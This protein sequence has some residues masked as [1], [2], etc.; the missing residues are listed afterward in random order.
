MNGIIHQCKQ[1]KTNE[2]EM[3]IAVFQYI[4][5]LVDI[6]RPKKY[7]FMG[8]DGNLPLMIVDPNKILLG[9]APRA[10][11]NE[12]RQR[13]WRSYAKNAKKNMKKD[14]NENEGEKEKGKGETPAATEPVGTADSTSVDPQSFDWACIYCT[15]INDMTEQKCGMCFS[16]RPKNEE[17]GNAIPTSL[18]L[19]PL[20][21]LQE[22]KK[23]QK[24]GR[25]KSALRSSTPSASPLAPPSCRG[26][27]NISTI[28]FEGK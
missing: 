7:L 18:L 20:P 15:Y 25:K 5:G 13:R 26:F 27:L 1:G 19:L 21:L 2:S 4:E 24:R 23:K 14:D 12:Q 11:Q 6:V 3:M 9:V 8:V 22:R 28:S 16:P 17:K 10:K